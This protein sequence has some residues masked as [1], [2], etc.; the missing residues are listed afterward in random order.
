MDTQPE[1][2]AQHYA[3]A[4]LTE[5][6]VA[7]WGKAGHYSTA[8]SAMAEAA[9]QFQ[10]ALDQLALLPDTPKR[11]RQELEIWSALGAVL[12]AVKGFAAPETGHAYARARELWEQLGSP[13]ESLYLRFGESAYYMI[14]GELDLKLSLDRD[15]LRLSRQRNDF[16]GL[17][18]GRLSAGQTLMLIGRFAQS[19]SD[20]EQVAALYDPTSH[21]SLVHLAGMH[22]QVVSLG[23]LSLVLFCLG[24]PDQAL[25]QGNAAI[26][27]ARKL[28]HP[29]SLALTLGC[30]NRLLSLIGDNSIF[31]ELAHELIAMAT[32]QAFPY[33]HAQG[34]IFAGWRKVKTGD[35][36]EGISLLRRGSTAFRA[37]GAELWAP[38]HNALLAAAFEIT[39]Q[40]EGA[41][42]LLDDG[43]Q[44]VERTGER[45]LESELIRHKGQLLLRQGYSA[46]A[47]E[48]YRDALIIAKEQEA[49][50]WELRAAV[51][52][53]RLRSDQDRRA[54]AR[55]LLTPVYGWFTE[56]FD[57]PDLKEAKALL[58]ALD[59]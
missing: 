28:A 17:V 50:L 41:V 19:R 58:D 11:Q 14:R 57:T 53:A 9:A 16:G 47:E 23:F 46:A 56:G 33:W 25:A 22:P 43:L 55:D 2:F 39:R 18:L 59:A 21:G 29:P 6:S 20:L 54:E 1:L 44:I 30:G 12:L 36:V 8:R 31:G 34:T 45:W 24:F 42:T 40:I 52:L 3:E 10:K 37:T 4:G 5:K 51:G 27:E 38:H 35:V 49:K 15:L 32:E 48:L 13:S 7:S 26:E